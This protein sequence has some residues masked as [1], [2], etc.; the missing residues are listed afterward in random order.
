MINDDIGLWAGIIMGIIVGAILMISFIDH[1]EGVVKKK[2][3]QEAIDNGV[4]EWKVTTNGVVYF[5]WKRFNE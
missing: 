5:E 3:Q 4:A 2:I 1:G